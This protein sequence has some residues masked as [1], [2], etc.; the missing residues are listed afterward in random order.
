M[1]RTTD[2]LIKTLCNNRRLIDEINS[3]GL[4]YYYDIERIMVANDE[5]IQELQRRG[6]F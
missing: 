4:S 1:H 2:F 6:V 3:S 5:I